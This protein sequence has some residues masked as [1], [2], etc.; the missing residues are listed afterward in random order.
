VISRGLRKVAAVLIPVVLIMGLGWD[1]WPAKV[2]AAEAVEPPAIGALAWTKN[3]ELAA[4]M[5]SLTQTVS[6]LV[7]VADDP[8]GLYQWHES[9]WAHRSALQG[10][11]GSVRSEWASNKDEMSAG[12][13]PATALYRHQELADQIGGRISTTLA[14]LNQALMSPASSDV[15]PEAVYELQ[16]N[17]EAWHRGAGPVWN[18]V[19]P[20]GPARSDAGIAPAPELGAPLT[21][22]LSQGAPTEADLAQETDIDDAVVVEVLTET[23]PDM[24][25]IA[26]WVYANIQVQWYM[27]R[28]KYPMAVLDERAGNDTDI[29]GLLVTLLRR[30]DIPARYAHGQVVIPKQHWSGLWGLSEQESAAQ[31]LA[32][33]GIPVQTQGDSNLVLPHTWVEAW[34]CHCRRWAALAVERRQRAAVSARQR[35]RPAFY[36]GEPTLARSVS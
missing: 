1:D 17:L 24:G 21:L 4:E 15:L 27:D 18:E 5:E 36:Q 33:S 10:L 14:L 32:G 9:L 23:G 19:L 6:G 3:L 20:F 26:S 31:F 22:P 34:D 8:G 30:S 16:E 13:V 25:R 28:Q 7:K 11:V 2:R 12:G 35:R 29:A